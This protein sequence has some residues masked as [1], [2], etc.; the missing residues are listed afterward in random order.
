M[1]TS[2][3]TVAFTTT[4]DAAPL[5]GG[6]TYF[7]VAAVATSELIVNRTDE[8]DDISGFG[9]SIAD[10][11]RYASTG[12]DWTDG[13]DSILMRVDGYEKVLDICDRSWRV[14]EAIVAATPSQD[15][16]ELVSVDEMAA[17][18]DLP[19]QP[20][21][22]SPPPTLPLYNTLKPRDF[23]GLTGLQT[24]DLSNAGLFVNFNQCDREALDPKFCWYGMLDP[25]VN[26]VEL[27]LSSDY[28]SGA[29]GVPNE[30]AG[31]LPEG[32]FSDL[33]NLETLRLRQTKL[34]GRFADGVF[35]GLGNLRELD[36]RGYAY[37]W[38]DRCA[39]GEPVHYPSPSYNDPNTDPEC[40][41]RGHGEALNPRYGSPLAFEPL[42]S[43][44][45]YN[46]DIRAPYATGNWS[47]PLT[48]PTGLGAVVS[49]IPTA[50]GG[51][52]TVTLVWSP[53]EDTPGIGSA[54]GT[55]AT[56]PMTGYHF[57]S[58]IY[59][60][61]QAPNWWRTSTATLISR[62]VWARTCS[63]TQT[64]PTETST[65]ATTAVGS[66]VPGRRGSTG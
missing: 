24:L 3:T 12:S 2:D 50:Q 4:G 55:T 28:S 38:L 31:H 49:K 62:R 16:C 48:E 51:H 17:I 6:T 27:D 66:M 10:G 37:V 53:P 33:S 7:L 61:L 30:I 21:F 22:R 9:W 20:G 36:L 46:H 45:T 64:A 44:E 56:F 54:T 18:T 14:H 1:V 26:L 58:V 13:T 60:L 40:A 57:M 32:L 25:L 47:A 8:D 15:S 23:D 63:I 11:S 42:V 65:S 43:L 52:T 39:N 41:A 19:F 5:A 35:A 29:G 34:W 59:A